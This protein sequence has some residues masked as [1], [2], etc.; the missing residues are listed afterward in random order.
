MSKA[1][2]KPWMKDL[3]VS[4]VTFAT[5]KAVE[6]T[7]AWSDTV[8]G[9]LTAAKAVH[10]VHAKISQKGPGGGTFAAWATEELGRSQATAS[11]L[12]AIGARYDR[13]IGASINLPPSWIALYELAKAP[14]AVFRR[15]LRRVRPEMTRAEVA[16]VVLQETPRDEPLPRTSPAPPPP[17]KGRKALGDEAP[18]ATPEPV[19]IPVQEIPV[20]PKDAAKRLVLNWGA[21]LRETRQLVQE[22]K[23]QQAALAPEARRFIEHNFIDRIECSL[24]DVRQEVLLQATTVQ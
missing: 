24:H 16:A 4:L 21:L 5:K 12:A 1:L 18:T 9:I 17:R 22:T 19:E 3:P 8:R 14:E 20:M 7:T 13:F 6:A 23:E 2:Q 10:E 15:A 11:Q